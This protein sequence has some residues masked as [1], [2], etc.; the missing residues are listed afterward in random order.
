MLAA[1]DE[2]RIGFVLDKM[3]CGVLSQGLRMETR[4]L[5]LTFILMVWPRES[6]VRT[7][8]SDLITL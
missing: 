5:A 6:T 2:L 8:R 3:T 1:Y 4:R 7:R